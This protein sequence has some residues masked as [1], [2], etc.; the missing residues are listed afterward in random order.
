MG[1]APVKLTKEVANVADG[2]KDEKFEINFRVGQRYTMIDHV[3]D[4]KG[5][6]QGDISQAIQ[7]YRL[8][9][10]TSGESLTE[11]L[12]PPA[13][14]ALPPSAPKQVSN[15][16]TKKQKQKPANKTKKNAEP[17]KDPTVR[18]WIKE[19]FGFAYGTALVDHVLCH[20]FDDGAFFDYDVKMSEVL[21]NSDLEN[22]VVQV[23]S[24]GF[25]DANH[26]M[27]SI[28]KGQTACEGWITQTEHKSHDTTQSSVLT[29]EEFHPY[30]F[31]QLSNTATPPIHYQTF[32]AAVD[33]FF[34]NA[35]TQRLAHRQ[36]STQNAAQKKLA[37]IAASH[38]QQVSR[39]HTATHTNARV[40]AAIEA[41]LE[42]VDAA[43]A[44]IRGLVTRGMDWGDIEA[45][46]REE[47][48]RSGGSG[49]VAGIVDGLELEKGIIKVILMDP[50]FEDDEEEDEDGDD[51]DDDSDNGNSSDRREKEKKRN[52]RE[53]QRRAAMM[54]IDLDINLSAW[55]N[56]RRYYDS[57]KLAAVNAEK[58]AVA[59][60]KAL[61]QAE[62][63]ITQDLKS[64]QAAVPVIRAIRTP[65]WFEKFM[66]FISSENYL[67]L[68][69]RDPV[70]TDTLLRKYMK[71]RD[72]V[73]SCDEEGAPV[74]LV[75]NPY[76]LSAQEPSAPSGLS[77]LAPVP[78]LTLQQAGCMAVAHSRA[79]EAK[80]VTSAW[81]VRGD[82]VIRNK[83]TFSIGKQEKTYLVGVYSLILRFADNLQPPT[84][85]IYGFGLLF[86]IDE[87]DTF[88]HYDERRPWARSGG[89]DA[90]NLRET[91]ATE[92]QQAVEESESN[93]EAIDE[94]A[95]E[96][97]N[98][99][100]ALT[101]A[102]DKKDVDSE[103]TPDSVV[104]DFDKYGLSTPLIME[105]SHDAYVNEN[106]DERTGEMSQPNSL[107]VKKRMTA[108]ER[109]LAKKDVKSEDRIR[110]DE[111][112]QNIESETSEDEN[113]IE[114][115]NVS[116]SRKSENS[117][118][119]DVASTVSK[120]SS[121]APL[122][123]GKKS[124]LRKMKEKYGQQSDEEREV[125]MSVLHGSPDLSKKDKPDSSKSKG[126]KGQ[127]A[128]S[129]PA[130]NQK[131]APKPHHSV[132]TGG[133]FTGDSAPVVGTELTVLDLLTSNPLD[134]D[135]VRFAVPVCAPWT[136][137]SKYKYK[138]KLIPG[139][140]KKGKAAKSA[141]TALIAAGKSSGDK[142]EM[143]LVSQ[144]VEV[145]LVTAMLGK[146]K[147]VG[148]SGN[149]GSKKT[150]R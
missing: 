17:Q 95:N 11:A 118:R 106:L 50:D 58:T 94:A 81:W 63:K 22:R 108:K 62:K 54:K 139:S 133:E 117:V 8:K 4:F 125:M 111:S 31:A 3:R 83:G 92:V 79:W 121:S 145:E 36:L 80:I 46:L 49:G 129:K 89:D 15:S 96:A 115:I 148:V 82:V 146:V 9:T 53:E 98:E 25:A 136:C 19:K 43:V 88:R 76:D 109:R 116:A 33:A 45:L 87:A 110:L 102:D 44:A 10:K 127:N 41:N 65:Y 138:L 93:M 37:T 71:S 39:L 101:A 142:R 55:A 13:E 137:L 128:H 66:W 21:N 85:L 29:Y 35:E 6:S 38:A 20:K 114:V 68:A 112:E 100:D 86:V 27:V 131:P 149:D 47:R 57:K 64:S 1:P 28:L 103:T 42:L 132:V 97:S 26:I 140:L 119:A 70:Q 123:R 134:D 91:E 104:A 150:K 122:P 107:P 99:T 56:A 84:Q 72:V 124:K 32:A 120:Q 14:A 59:V 12:E 141:E 135:T 24:L 2:S 105:S 34:T 61:K 90:A 144:L 143:E 40:A 16:K 77:R 75:I 69:G 52:D 7:E 74:V 126:S 113:E 5:I 147:I 30:Q 23:L 48:R 73:V 18:K 60:S 78:P 130:A 67:I 51:S